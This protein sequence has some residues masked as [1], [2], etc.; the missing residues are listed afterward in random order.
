MGILAWILLGLVAGALA[1][2]IMPGQQGGGIVVTGALGVVGAIV[3]G[4]LGAYVLPDG[5]RRTA[6]IPPA[7]EDAMLVLSRKC[8]ERILIG[9]NIELTVVDIGGNK[10]RLAVDAPRDVSIHRQEIYRRI[11]VQDE[12]RHGISIAVNESR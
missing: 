4:G 11:Q 3:G 7:Q 1:K 12:S 9:P 6:P 5:T 10:V 2:F 8:G